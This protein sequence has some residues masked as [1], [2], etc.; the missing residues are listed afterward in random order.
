MKK[1]Y[2]HILYAGSYKELTMTDRF[3]PH[4]KVALKKMSLTVNSYQCLKSRKDI[5]ENPEIDNSFHTK[6]V[7]LVKVFEPKVPNI[8]A[9]PLNKRVPIYNSKIIFNSKREILSLLDFLIYDFK[10]L[11]RLNNKKPVIT[12]NISEDYKRL[13]ISVPIVEVEEIATYSLTGELNLEIKTVNIIIDFHFK[14]Q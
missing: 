3:R 5:E 12:F 13:G 8:H 6:V 4:K 9:T 10:V 2:N 7:S 14:F 1:N 11:D